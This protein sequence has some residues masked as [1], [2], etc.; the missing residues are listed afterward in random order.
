MSLVLVTLERFF[1][2]AAPAA[3]G[4]L[5]VVAFSGGPDSTA[6]LAGLARIAPRRGLRLVAAHLDHGLDPGSARRAAAAGRLAARLGVELVSER[7]RVAAFARPGESPE[8]AARRVR[9]GFLEEIRSA[10]GGRWIATAHHRDDQ[11]ETV[12]LRLLQG[13]GLE[14]LAGVQP[15]R[16]RVVRPLLELGR[17]QLAA[18]LGAGLG[19]GLPAAPVLDPTNRDLRV[20]RNR[21]RAT[22]LPALERS[23]PGSSEALARRAGAALSAR[24]AL[25]RR[26]EAALEPIC[27]AGGVAV[28]RDAYEALPAPLRPHALALLHRRAGAPYPAS[29]AAREELARQLGGPGGSR[30]GCDGPGGWRWSSDGALLVLHPAPAAP[31]SFSYTLALPG[32]VEIPELGVTV[33]VRREPAAPWMYRGSPRRAALALPGAA[34]PEPASRPGGAPQGGSRPEGPVAVVRSRRPGDRL[35]PLGSPGT[36]KLKDVLIDRRVPRR[37]R[38]RLPL[39]VVGGRIAWV[40]GVTVDEAFRLPGGQG[41]GG[42]ETWTAEVIT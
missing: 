31:P 27:D 18:E 29:R 28:R 10:R 41:P 20:P 6:L 13:S 34:E 2:A 3:Q 39:L 15:V 16:G 21:V 36:R 17:A 19:A 26:L 32:E 9:Y 35:R 1:T 23:A 37:E 38:D 5:V 33:R 42:G 7:R 40:P 12:L 8:A 4:D 25:E 14:G 22:L 30:I 11:A 24:G